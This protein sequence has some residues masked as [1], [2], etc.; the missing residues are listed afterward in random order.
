MPSPNLSLPCPHKWGWT[1]IMR[2][3]DEHTYLQRQRSLSNERKGYA[4]KSQSL[5]PFSG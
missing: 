1:N 3:R 2:R 4:K 5:S